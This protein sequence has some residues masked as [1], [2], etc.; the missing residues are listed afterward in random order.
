MGK[1][2]L[3]DKSGANK[4]KLIRTRKDIARIRLSLSY[5]Q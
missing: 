4:K 1:K 5:W 2:A 3:K